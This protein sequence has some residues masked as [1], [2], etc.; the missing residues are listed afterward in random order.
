MWAPA[1]FSMF[2]FTLLSIMKVTYRPESLMPGNYGK[3]LAPAELQDLLAFLSRQVTHP[4][5]CRVHD[6]AVG[7]DR[8]IY[9]AETRT[10]R[11]VKLRPVK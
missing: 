10:K 6:I 2:A 11:V 7:Q 9:V 4:N 5:V 1:F 3:V 8:S